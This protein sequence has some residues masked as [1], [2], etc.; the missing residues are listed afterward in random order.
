VGAG[1][2]RP[3]SGEE[4]ESRAVERLTLVGITEPASRL[5]QYPHQLSGGMRQRVMIAMAIACRPSLIL[6]DEPTTALDVTIQAHILELLNRIQ[7]EM[8]MALVLVTHDLGLI[9]ERA[10]EVAVM[11]AGRIVEQAG[12]K[13][14]FDHPMH[15]YTRGLIASVPQP[16][17]ERGKRLRTIAGSVPRLID[18]PEGCT[19][20][21][22]CEI[23]TGACEREPQ[24]REVKPGHLV[25]CWNAA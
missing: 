10:H 24:L 25:R 19:F 1:D 8:G 14:L 11:Y 22:R 6:A 9:A 4:R 17:K 16:G 7:T 15:P 5:D 21:T 20:I 13:E 23:K 18:L 12:T 3:V 2:H